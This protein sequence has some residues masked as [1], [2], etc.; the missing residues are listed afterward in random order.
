M[1]AGKM[2]TLQYFKVLALNT[3]LTL[4]SQCLIG[5]VP[6][7]PYSYVDKYLKC[8]TAYNEK[9]PSCVSQFS[10]QLSI[11]PLRNRGASFFITNYQLP[12]T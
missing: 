5:A 10:Y 7:L 3:E 6:S 11:T 12:I 1:L 2:L 9:P 8:H 4:L